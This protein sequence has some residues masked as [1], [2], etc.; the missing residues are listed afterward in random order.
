MIR[1]SE[2]YLQQGTANNFLNIL[3]EKSS[4]LHHIVDQMSYVDYLTRLMAIVMPYVGVSIN[5]KNHKLNAEQFL[6]HY[7]IELNCI[8]S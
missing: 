8:F 1:Y 6:A 3:S 7:A 4:I 2:N 5:S